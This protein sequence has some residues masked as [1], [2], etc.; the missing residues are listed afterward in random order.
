[1][2]HVA[3][4]P[5]CVL[6]PDNPPRPRP[7]VET[8]T[9]SLPLSWSRKANEADFN[10]PTFSPS[11][12]TKLVVKIPSFTRR[13][14]IHSPERD[15]PARG[16]LHSPTSPPRVIPLYL[17]P[18]S[19]SPAEEGFRALSSS[20]S[21]PSSALTVV[22]PTV[23]LRP[24]CQACYNKILL[25]MDD[26]YV[27]KWSPGARRKKERDER[28]ATICSPSKLH[29]SIDVM[30]DE[31]YSPCVFG[32]ARVDE[33]EVQR[34]KGATTK[35]DEEHEKDGETTDED[36]GDMPSPRHMHDLPNP[37]DMPKLAPPMSP[38]A[39]DRAFADMLPQPASPPAH[40][41][42]SVSPPS[43]VSPP[44]HDRRQS[45][46]ERSSSMLQACLRGGTAVLKSVASGEGNVN[47]KLL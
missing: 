17:P 4:S 29:Y 7:H 1:M 34:G 8:R 38:S 11:R 43:T 10:D 13:A 16:C 27:P 41:P 33:V 47:I 25:A 19:E 24:C 42:R 44:G 36:A 30:L 21:P 18:V 20:S 22:S 31:S 39:E 40:H 28:E 26:D 32:R 6:I 9:L 14:R 23:P 35:T 15:H 37:F 46:T 2:A 3:F 45:F 12:P 5:Q